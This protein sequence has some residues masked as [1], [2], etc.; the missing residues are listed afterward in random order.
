MAA[1]EYLPLFGTDNYAKALFH[2]LLVD[3]N[4]PSR[5]P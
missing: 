1:E 2:A 5:W 4:V 3:D